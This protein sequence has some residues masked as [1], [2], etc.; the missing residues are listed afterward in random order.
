[1][2]KKPCIYI[3]RT[4]V[5]LSITPVSIYSPYIS[6]IYIPLKRFKE[7][8]RSYTFD[9]MSTIPKRTFIL[10]KSSLLRMQLKITPTPSTPKLMMFHSFFY[11]KYNVFIYYKK[12][13][14]KLRLI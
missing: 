4:S 14:F 8:T 10:L 12:N 1:M 7:E 13:R 2:K 6:I 11:K 3:E 9:L 5:K